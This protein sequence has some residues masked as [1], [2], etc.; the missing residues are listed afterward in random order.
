MT[1]ND[2]PVGVAGLRGERDVDLG[3][4]RS[5]HLV[6]DESGFALED[7]E[8]EED[9]GRGALDVDVG[10]AE[11]EPEPEVDEAPPLPPLPPPPLLED[12]PLSPT[13]AATAG[14]GNTYS[15][16][17]SKIEGSKI[18]GSSSEYPPGKLTSSLDFGVPV[19]DPPT[20]S[21]AQAG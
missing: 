1:S 16:P 21:C 11:P 20:L 17:S 8:P 2:R 9:V 6:E 14:P 12:P 7:E 5:L 13:K 4:L 19:P 10:L 18:P 15:T 3:T